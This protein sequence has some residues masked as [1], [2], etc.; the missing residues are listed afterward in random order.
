MP[1][2]WRKCCCWTGRMSKSYVAIW[3]ILLLLA[4][5]GPA[6]TVTPAIAPTA[7]PTP[8]ETVTAIPTET[9]TLT[10]TA[11][12]TSEPEWYRPLDASLGGLKYQY[13]EVTNAHARVYAT[14]DDAVAQNGNYG[15]LPNFPAYVAY[16]ATKMGSNGSTY[17]LIN[18]GWIVAEDLRLL[19]PSTFTGLLLTRE[20]PFRFGW[21]L[22]DTESVSSSGAP[23][24]DYKRFE[25]VHEAA[26]SVEKAGYISVGEDEWLP[27][28]A[29]ALTSV[30]VPADAGPNTCRF[31]YANLSAEIL[32]V[33]DGCKLVFATLIAT[34]K[35]SWTFTGRFAILNKWEYLTINSPDWSASDYYM[36]GIPD[37]MSY[38]GDFGF[39]G[40]Y[41][42]AE[43]GSASSHGC[44]NLSPADAKW[45]YQWAGLGERVIISKG[46]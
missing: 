44:I 38:A 9:Q 25:V 7:S 20:V 41:W 3:A 23:V 16:T 32:T 27:E 36:E 15:H 12:A 31:I 8:T 42:N 24:R 18:Y 40:N 26:A 28:T 10:P 1:A 39:H 35:N 33:F 29:V 34:G 13:A 2:Y 14:I 21:V 43:F 6:T 46:N 4:A 45:L 17:Y 11:T 22:A 19:T 37:F 5:C 30:Q